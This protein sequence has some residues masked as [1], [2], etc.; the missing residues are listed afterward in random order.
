MG[1]KS[2]TF[3]R[4]ALELARQN[5]HLCP[6]GLDLEQAEHSMALRDTLL[7]RYLQARQLAET[8]EVAMQV[9]G[10]DAFDG[11]RTAYKS[12]KANCRDAALL[13]LIDHLGRNFRSRRSPEVAQP[14]SAA[15]NEVRAAI[16][17]RSEQ[18]MQPRGKSMPT[19]VPPHL[20]T[21]SHEVVSN[22]GNDRNGIR[23]VSNAPGPLSRYPSGI[24]SRRSR[25]IWI[26]GRSAHLATSQNAPSTAANARR[27]RATFTQ[28]SDLTGS[29]AQNAT[30]G[31]CL[32]RLR[33]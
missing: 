31:A 14:E 9:C 21:G 28:P 3:S 33:P 4:E 18:A 24:I 23:P 17:S 12:M 1:L 5:P 29:A 30:A 25:I 27:A 22:E 10:V 11:A 13:E 7:S 6:G 20:V 26:D 15:P 2:E 16:A 32:N 19:P 8:L